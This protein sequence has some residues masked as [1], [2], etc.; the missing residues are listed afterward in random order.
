MYASRKVFC[1]ILARGG[2]KGVPRKNVRMIAGKPLIAHS[3]EVAKNTKY[4][5]QIFVSTEDPEIKKISIKY[6]AT[7]IDRPKEL[8][9]DTSLYLDAVKHL[10]SVVPKLQ[11]NNPIIVMLSPTSPIRKTLDVEKCVELL[12]ENVDSVVSVIEAKIHPSRMLVKQDASLMHF[13]L[14]ELPISNRQEAEPLFAINGSIYVTNL[15]LL[16]NQQYYILGG[17]I[18]GYLMDEKHSIDID[19]EFDFDV[20]KLLMEK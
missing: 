9:S 7:V 20:C 3:I 17:R 12:D 8:A 5:D 6:G 4:I 2:S 18:K 15:D 10:I 14:N 13:Y 19:T 11:K 16:K 1:F